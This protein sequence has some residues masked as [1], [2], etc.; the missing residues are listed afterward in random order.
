VEVPRLEQVEERLDGG[1]VE[2]VIGITR[3]YGSSLRGRKS[4]SLA[5]AA[6]SMPIPQ[7]ASPAATVSA[8]ARCPLTIFS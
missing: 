4:R 1:Q 8:V 3:S 2:E 7:S 5:R 6:A